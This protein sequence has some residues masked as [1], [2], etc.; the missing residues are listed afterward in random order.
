[1]EG[2]IGEIRLF[3]G[4]FAPRSWALCQGQL[5]AISSN[6]ALFSILGTVYGGDGRSTFALPDLRGRSAVGQGHGA[7]LSQYTLGER[8]GNEYTTL[9]VANLPAHTHTA[10]MTAETAAAT[11]ANPTNRLLGLGTTAM[12]AD[13]APADEI[14]MHPDSVKV[15]STGSNTAFS[16]VSPVLAL[17]FIICLQGVY[18]SR[19]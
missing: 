18:P 4:N 7:G 15:G 8:T 9:Q 6:S 2:T 12:Y 13:A 16:N 11:E 19:S 1:M 3:A 14:A 10:Q 17:N 5:L